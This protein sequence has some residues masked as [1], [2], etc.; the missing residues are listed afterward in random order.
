MIIVII[1]IRSSSISIISII[2]QWQKGITCSQ[3]APRDV[4]TSSSGSQ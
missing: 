3:D 1:V 2:T 4:K